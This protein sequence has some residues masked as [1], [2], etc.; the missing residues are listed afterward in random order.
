MLKL[1]TVFN[2]IVNQTSWFTK[3]QMAKKYVLLFFLSH[4]AALERIFETPLPNKYL[5]RKFVTW[6][7]PWCLWNHAR[8]TNWV[9]IFFKRFPVLHYSV[10]GRVV[11]EREESLD[12][13]CGVRDLTEWAVQGNDTNGGDLGGGGASP[14]TERAR[15]QWRVRDAE[16][17]T[18]CNTT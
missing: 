12:V 5:L 6:L 16:E 1:M 7:P 3:V 13:S 15:I 9:K 11:G 14:Q 2:H 8:P 4:N 10:E 17:G 18:V